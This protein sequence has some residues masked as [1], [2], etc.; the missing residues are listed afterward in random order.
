MIVI[1]LHYR[2]QML[3]DHLAKRHDVEIRYSDETDEILGTGG[4]VVK[5]LP[6]FE[7]EPF[8]ILNSDSVWVE[9]YGPALDRMMQRCGT[10]DAH[11]R[12]AA[13]GRHDHRHGL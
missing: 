9:G 1:N 7:G 4:G 6:H 13:A 3:N 8:F 10:P 2:P 11:G 5:A 12:A